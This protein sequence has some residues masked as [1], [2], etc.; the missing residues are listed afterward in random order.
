MVST[1][2]ELARTG[3]R[4]ENGIAPARRPAMSIMGRQRGSTLPGREGKYEMPYQL[5]RKYR[6]MACAFHL[7][8][9]GHTT[10]SCV[11]SA[12][13]ET[14]RTVSAF[15]P[16]FSAHLGANSIYGRR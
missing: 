13:A 16:N 7:A 5:V 6:I 3:T 10:T 14:R 1:E 4:V 12:R 9:G 15:L 8:G 11:V 2:V